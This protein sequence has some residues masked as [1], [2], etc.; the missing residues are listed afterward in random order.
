[1]AT[2]I[3]SIE[4]IGEN[5][6][7]ID[8]VTQDNLIYWIEQSK[9]GE[10]DRA[11]HIKDVKENLRFS[12]LTGKV[13]TLGLYDLERKK[14][15]IYYTAEGKI[16]NK[17]VDEFVLKASNE[18]NIL[19]DFWEGAKSY[20]TFVTFCGRSFVIPFILH[21]SLVHNL[22]PTKNLMNSRYLSLQQNT[23]HVDLQD[24][25]TFYGAMRRRPSLHMFCRTYGIDSPRQI[26]ENNSV[27]EFYRQKKFLD[28]AHHSMANVIAT[29][30]L[31]QKWYSYLAPESFKNIDF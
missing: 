14:G 16:E 8:E 19:E 12:P 7:D 5:W 27:P 6:E 31:Y 17:K 20:D 21:R 4:T 23:S 9:R 18:K 1:M 22:L 2:L 13:I 11:K 15:V 24:Q 30:K 28:I 25:L 26:N 3:V 29:T 10:S